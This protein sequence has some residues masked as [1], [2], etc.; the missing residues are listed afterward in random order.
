LTLNEATKLR[1]LADGVE[2]DDVETFKKKVEIIKESSF[3]KPSTGAKVLTETLEEVNEDNKSEPENT[4]PPE[5]QKYVNAL[6]RT[7]R[8]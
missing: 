4:V 7:S 6:T 5:M 3:V 8:K 1:E 2:S